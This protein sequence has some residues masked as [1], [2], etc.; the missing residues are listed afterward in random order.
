VGGGLSRNVIKGGGMGEHG[1][2]F[3]VKRGGMVSQ[4]KGTLEGLQGVT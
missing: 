1:L 3:K 2:G 4:E